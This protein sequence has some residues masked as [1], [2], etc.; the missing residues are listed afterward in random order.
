MA[1]E[2]QLWLHFIV[3][4]LG[5]M[6]VIVENVNFTTDCLGGNNIDALRHI[7]RFIDFSLMINL[8]FD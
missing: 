3:L 5:R 2:L 8:S 4:W 6:L 1:E 7:P